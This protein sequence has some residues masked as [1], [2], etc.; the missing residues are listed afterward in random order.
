MPLDIFNGLGSITPAMLHIRAS[1]ISKPA[2]REE[3]ILSGSI[4]GDLGAEGIQSP[5]AKDPVGVALGS[6]YRQ[7]SLKFDSGYGYQHGDEEGTGPILP[8]PLSSFNV[9]EVFGEVRIP[10]AQGLPFFEDLSVNGGYRYSSYSNVGAVRSWK[11]GAEWQPIDDFRLRAS[12]QR[13]V[14]APNVLE[15]FAPAAIGLF[16]GNDPCASSTA[17]Q[18]AFVK[19]AGNAAVLTCPASQCNRAIGW[20]PQSEPGNL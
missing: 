9:A 17:G 2:I 12:F 19:N 16:S 6:E 14:R 15:S 3:H 11:Y 18:C 10:V 8:T 5:W 20:Q 4:S 1:R 7:E 13:A